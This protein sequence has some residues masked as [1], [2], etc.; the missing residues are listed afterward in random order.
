MA[1]RVYS[2]PRPVVRPVLLL[3]TVVATVVT[4]AEPAPAP[5]A[6]TPDPQKRADAAGWEWSDENDLLRCVRNLDDYE[7]RITRAKGARPPDG[8]RVAVFDGATEVFAID[9]HR[10]T[11]LT[12]RGGVAFVADFDPGA[13]G[14]AVVAFDLKNRKELW[15]A[16]LRGNP[17]PFHSAYRHQVVFRWEEKWLVVYGDEANGRYIEFLDPATGKTV[18]H[19][20]LPPQR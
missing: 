9:G 1:R 16:E 17:P 14:C 3:F 12:R 10:A 7:V 5:R 4:A 2:P 19:K 20:K 13:T 6:V 11:V 8:L 18:G 15:R